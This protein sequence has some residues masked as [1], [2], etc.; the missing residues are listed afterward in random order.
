MDNNR[1]HLYH[2]TEKWKDFAMLA[3]IFQVKLSLH[4]KEKNLP[5]SRVRSLCGTKVRNC[6][7]MLSQIKDKLNKP[8]PVLTMTGD[9]DATNREQEVLRLKRMSKSPYC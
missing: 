7:A 4:L 1:K 2:A 3:E 9:D 8:N 6:A 5:S